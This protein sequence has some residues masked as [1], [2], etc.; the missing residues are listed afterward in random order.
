MSTDSARRRASYG[1]TSP[2]IGTR[3]SR[4]RG[5]IIAETL[6]LF[7]DQ[8]F[9]D[10]TVHD[11]ADAAE[12]SRAA[13]YQYFASKDEIV[14]ELHDE[15]GRALMGMMDG[16]GPIGP[17]AGGLEQL[18]SWIAAWSAVHA[19][20]GALFVRWAG[21]GLPD[22]S[23]H[24]PEHDL[25]LTH[26][27]EAGGQCA[28][29]PADAAA[30]LTGVVHR[31]SFLQFAVPGSHAEEPG[32]V[33]EVATA[34]QMVLFPT[35]PGEVLRA[36]RVRE[37]TGRADPVVSRRARPSRLDGITA[38]LSDRS[39]QTVRRIAR[40]GAE[41]FAVHGYH[42]ANVD[43]IVRQAGFARGTFYKYF[44]DKLDLLVALAEAFEDAAIVHVRALGHIPTGACGAA[45]RLAWAGELVTFR[46][47]HLGAVRSLIDRSPGHAD[48]DA[49]S[50]RLDELIASALR[51]VMADTAAADIVTPWGAQVVMVGALDRRPTAE[52]VT[53]VVE[54]GLLGG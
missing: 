30:L 47:K 8:G 35:T 36:A 50:E 39:A 15:C 18:R 2:Q 54:R 41:S 34:L 17:T 33:D 46:R 16:I 6:V 52:L 21:V 32:A 9:H 51:T 20:Y 24:L 53:T 42:G 11:I 13:L 7:A 22:G 26:L 3:G 25:R 14:R 38:A 48:L 28:M 31:Y 4:T 1:P 27:L 23:G 5:K 43:E 19:R 49:C 37:P 45:E 10:T 40:A 12:V 29:S 44:A